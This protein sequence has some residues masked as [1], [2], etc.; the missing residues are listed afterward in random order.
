MFPKIGLKKCK[1]VSTKRTRLTEL[2]KFINNL[3][4]KSLKEILRILRSS[5][6]G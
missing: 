4:Y 1:I 2:L 6:V 3:R 5:N